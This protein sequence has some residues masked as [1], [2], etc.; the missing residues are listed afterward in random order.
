MPPL[1]S[2]PARPT[3]ASRAGS[4]LS[5]IAPLALL[6]ALFG[7]HAAPDA[8]PPLS[9]AATRA[10]AAQPGVATEPLAR[11]ADALFTAPGIGRTDA[12]LVL[13]KGRP[14]VERY[15]EGFSPA[16][17]FLGWSMS[18]TVTGVLIGLLVADGR[19]RLD[20]PAPVPHW[21]RPGDPRGEI[22]LRSL[23]QMRSGL[24]NREGGEAHEHDDAIAMLFLEGRDDMAAYAEAQPLENETGKV[25][26]YST[27]TSVILADIATDTLTTSPSPA[28]RRAAM[29]DYLRARLFDPLGLKSMVGEYDAAG[30]LEGGSMIHATARDWGRL[31]EFLRNG[32]AV[33]GAQILPSDWVRFMTAPSPAN[34]AYG[35]QVW[36]NRPAA[37]GK[38]E[39]FPGQAPASL[40]AAVGHLGQ[41]VIVSPAQQLTVVRL[42]R[43]SEA[44]RAALRPLLADLVRQFPVTGA[45]AGG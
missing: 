5:L 2:S 45:R 15:G 27:A 30:T 13:Y 33:R 24:A 22:S 1:P 10:V 39:L 8:P 28:A 41:Y 4:R 37:D 19:L 18:K 21:Q 17:R 12:L 44:E 16:S 11:A 38:D 34:P 43:S 26:D 25:F 32:G 42:G 40:F 14:V 9:A 23:L 6:P 35:A 3:L 29:A 36:L 7:C 31:G 20:E